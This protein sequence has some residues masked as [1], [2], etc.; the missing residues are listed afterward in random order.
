MLIRTSCSQ[1]RSHAYLFCVIP[2][3]TDFRGKERLLAVYTVTHCKGGKFTNF[4]ITLSWRFNFFMT[5]K[6]FAFLYIRSVSCA[7]ISRTSEVLHSWNFLSFFPRCPRGWRV[8]PA[9]SYHADNVRKQYIMFSIRILSFFFFRAPVC[10]Y[11]ICTLW[12]LAR[13]FAKETRLKRQLLQH[14]TSPQE[15]PDIQTADEVCVG[16]SR[17]NGI[18]ELCEGKLPSESASCKIYAFEYAYKE[19]FL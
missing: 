7:Q 5:K 3:P 16:D 10:D 11:G 12:R 9:L 19:Q 17:W 2:G 13:L 18:F 8:Y 15:E 6:I 1:S 4:L 14:R